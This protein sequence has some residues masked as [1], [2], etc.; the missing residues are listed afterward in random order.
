MVTIRRSNMA[1]V[2]FFFYSRPQHAQIDPRPIRKEN[3]LGAE[4]AGGKFS[5]ASR[6]ARGT[7]RGGLRDVRMTHNV[8]IGSTYHLSCGISR[9]ARTAPDEPQNIC[10][11]KEEKGRRGRKGGGGEERRREKM[12]HR[13]IRRL[14]IERNSTWRFCRRIWVTL[15]RPS[16]K[17]HVG[18]LPL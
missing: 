15:A 4:L 6:S 12:L 16:A 10:S 9:V 1:A 2:I 11:P 7:H 18:F 3:A 13:R 5:S 8:A 14:E 17:T